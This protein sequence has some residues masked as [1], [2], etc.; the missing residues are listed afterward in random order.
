MCFSQPGRF[1]ISTQQYHILRSQE[2]ERKHWFQ[3]L[4]FRFFIKVLGFRILG[5]QALGFIVL[6]SLKKNAFALLAGF[7]HVNIGYLRDQHGETQQGCSDVFQNL[8]SG[9]D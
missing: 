9:Y 5:F 7:E 3:D 6:E 1:S 4:G 2:D 8:P